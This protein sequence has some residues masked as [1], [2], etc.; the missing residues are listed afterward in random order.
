MAKKTEPVLAKLNT[1]KLT[2]E[3]HSSALRAWQC[4]RS[5][6]R[7]F[8]PQNLPL[9]T[10][11]L[12]QELEPLHVVGSPN[13]KK[14]SFFSGFSSA[15]FINNKSIQKA[16]LCI[17][18][19]LLHEE[20]ERLAWGSVLKVMLFD[21]DRNIGL[22]SM[23]E[24]INQHMPEGLCREFFGRKTLSRPRLA[25]LSGASETALRWQGEQDKSP[26]NFNESILSKILKK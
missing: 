23:Y 24:S 26:N 25:E 10:I 22:G 7:Q 19:R 8:S 1:D 20:I 3:C 12:L 2:I 14:Y 13:N 6:S 21:L 17:H 4:W 11:M 18:K 5:L 15:V 9:E 16:T